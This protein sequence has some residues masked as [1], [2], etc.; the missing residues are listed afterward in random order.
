MNRVIAELLDYCD[1]SVETTAIETNCYDEETNTIYLNFFEV[2]GLDGSLK[3]LLGRPSIKD[4]SLAHELGHAFFAKEEVCRSRKAQELFGDFDKKYRGTT[5]LIL[6]PLLRENDDYVTKYAQ[7]HPEEDFAD[8]FAFVVINGNRI[9]T[10]ADGEVKRKM[11][12]IRKLVN[13]ALS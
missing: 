13:K 1:V 4:F 7:T 10:D 5:G 2:M 8:S 9:P 6:S 12:F 3:S 11:S